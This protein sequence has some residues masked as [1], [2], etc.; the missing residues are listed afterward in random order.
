[1]M[2]YST[3]VKQLYVTCVAATNSSRESSR[4]S[5]RDQL[6]CYQRTLDIAKCVPGTHVSSAK[7]HPALAWLYSPPGGDSRR[8]DRGCLLARTSTYNL[9]REFRQLLEAESEDKPDW[10]L[11]FLTDIMGHLSILNQRLQGNN[12]MFPTL[13]SSIQAF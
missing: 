8:L 5:H 7:Y 11:A 12:N 1:M 9:R 10:E 3:Y 4:E 13:F 2:F 6:D